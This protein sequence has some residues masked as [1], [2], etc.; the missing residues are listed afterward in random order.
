MRDIL[1][2]FHSSTHL[3][4][5]SSTHPIIRINPS[6]DDQIRA[7]QRRLATIESALRAC[8][9]ANRLTD[10]ETFSPQPHVQQN[11]QPTPLH[12]PPGEPSPGSLQGA[13]SS[14]SAHLTTMSHRSDLP[15]LGSEEATWR[16]PVKS[17]YMYFHG[18]DGPGIDNGRPPN[19]CGAHILSDPQGDQLLQM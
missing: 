16:H 8:L 12:K 1:R 17:T 3:S 18:I 9:Q 4:T 19:P 6:S 5:H 7:L 15:L 10:L 13:P 11:L 14:V 2:Q